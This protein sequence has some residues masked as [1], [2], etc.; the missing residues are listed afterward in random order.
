MRK[1]RMGSWEWHL[2]FA[3][4][5]GCFLLV[6]GQGRAQLA[7]PSRPGEDKPELVI[8]E[9]SGKIRTV[10]LSKIGPPKILTKKEQQDLIAAKKLLDQDQLEAAI[11]LL[12]SLHKRAPHD[13]L[14][15]YPPEYGKSPNV[16]PFVLDPENLL[17]AAYYRAKRWKELYPLLKRQ[18]DRGAPELLE[19]NHL[20][21]GMYLEARKNVVGQNP[22]KV[23]PIVMSDKPFSIAD[24]PS[25]QVH[26]EQIFVAADVAA[27]TLGLKV[28]TERSQVAFS[29]NEK[30]LILKVHEK[31]SSQ[32]KTDAFMSG[33]RAFVPLR[34]VAESFGVRL[35]WDEKTRIAQLLPADPHAQA[36]EAKPQ[37]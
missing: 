15:Y 2:R 24:A 9:R 6:T 19:G 12:A 27:K 31:A 8:I 25:V 23:S 7:L 14:V 29:T 5:I 26:K 37:G 1:H 20:L 3:L 32:G 35:K 34:F 4:L 18:I 17:T 33:G 28:R 10:D 16:Q 22:S 21:M 11:R 13:M 30:T 36:K